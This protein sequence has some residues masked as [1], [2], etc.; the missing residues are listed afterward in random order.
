M[1][2]P[3]GSQKVRLTDLHS[4]SPPLSAGGQLTVPDF[5]KGRRG[6]GEVRKKMSAWDDL[7]S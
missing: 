3:S 4:I 5:E 7:K 6:E 2:L 1:K